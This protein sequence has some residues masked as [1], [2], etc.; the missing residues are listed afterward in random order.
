M[1]SRTTAIL[2][3]LLLVLAFWLVVQRTR[4]SVPVFWVRRLP[5]GYNALT[6]PPIGVFIRAEHRENTALL[7]HETIHWQQYQREGLLPFL[8]KYGRA[9]SQ[10]GYD[11]NPYEIEAR[12]LETPYC[13]HQ[14]TEC[15][16]TGQ[17]RTVYNPEFRY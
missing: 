11:G 7:D 4:H 12:H 6:L 10:H 3:W 8:W 15:V 9:A 16:R 1:N 2:L 17:A 13:Q 14:Y 5:N